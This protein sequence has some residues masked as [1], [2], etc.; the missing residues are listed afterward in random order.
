MP[1]TIAII[2]VISGSSSIELDRDCGTSRAVYREDS[3]ESSHRMA[4]QEHWVRIEAMLHSIRLHDLTV[5][6]NHTTHPRSNHSSIDRSE[7][8]L[9]AYGWLSLSRS[10]VLDELHHV[11]NVVLKVLNVRSI[12][13]AALH[14]KINRVYRSV[15]LAPHAVPSTMTLVIQ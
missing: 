9:D 12:S 5:L 2:L 11:I 7:L 4:E 10:L 6:V 3:D 13:V 14:T 8:L 15:T 1:G